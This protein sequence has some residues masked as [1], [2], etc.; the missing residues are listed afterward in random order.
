MPCWKEISTP[1][2]A[3]RSERV[4]HP[5]I[6]GLVGVV[7]ADPVIEKIPEDVKR[8][9]GARLLGEEAQE[10]GG[11]VRPPGREVQIGD[12]ERRALHDDPGAGC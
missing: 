9:A 4:Q 3:T 5:A 12:E 6:E 11:H 8:G 10:P 2:A 1:V 7:V